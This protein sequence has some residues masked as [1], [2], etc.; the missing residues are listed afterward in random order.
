M[1]TSVYETVEIEM[2]DGTKLE[3]KP[4][5]IKVLREFM[6]EFQKISNEEI[7]KRRALIYAQ[8]PILSVQNLA[9]WYPIKKGIFAKAKNFHK[10]VDEVSFE[11]YP[12][13]TLGLVGESGCGKSV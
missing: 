12:G 2:Q 13:E 8:K 3:M 6:K 10:A 4:L 11:I 9:K 1:A 7:K 5:K